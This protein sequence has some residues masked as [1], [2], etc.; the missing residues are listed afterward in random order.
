[1]VRAASRGEAPYDRA[2][3]TLTMPMTAPSTTA[4]SGLDPALTLLF[5]CGTGLAVA[6]LYY[7][8]PML[9]VIG[10]DL[11]AS[12]RALGLIPMLTQ[13]GY[14]IGIALLA[15]LGDRHD[16]RRVI[17]LKALALVVALLAAAHAPTLAGLG[18]ASLAVG[19][20]ATL[21]QDIVPAAAALAPA[22]VRG[23]VVGQV[24]MGLLLGILL[25]RVIS[26][27]VAARYGWRVMFDGAALSI[28]LLA[29][30][31][32]RRLPAMKPTTTLRYRALLA[33]LAVLWRRHR[34]LRAAAWAQGL[35]MVAFG[36]FWSTLA[37]ALHAAPFHLGSAAAG[38]YGLAGAAGALA[39]PLAGRVA[40]RRG[41]GAVTQLGTALVTVSFAALLLV[42]SL[43]A[44]AALWLIGVA[45][46][47]F[48]LGIQATLVAHQTIIYSLDADA[49]SRVNAV[50]IFAMFVG[51]ASGSALGSMLFGAAGWT[52]VAALATLAAGGA[53]LVRWRSR[54]RQ[55]TH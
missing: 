5:A 8:Q 22:S 36:A 55:H 25:S 13:L 15:P 27:A 29:V 2:D 54:Q 10:A 44:H 40:D 32:A 16:R 43:G 26:G 51:M 1:M 42:P 21:A 3:L 14:A 34:P 17:V 49:R 50:L 45:S 23:R 6:T 41:P 28:A 20:F 37:I 39:A 33:S 30:V 12:P 31:A 4:A 38:A 9:A 35:L 24:M 47:G 52:A 53:F 48:D 11:G 46:V 18:V 7:N 19:V